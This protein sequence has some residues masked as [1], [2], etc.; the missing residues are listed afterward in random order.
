MASHRRSKRRS[1]GFSSSMRWISRNGSTNSYRYGPMCV[2][3]TGRHGR[4]K[5]TVCWTPS[6]I[7]PAYPPTMSLLG[8]TRMPWNRNTPSSAENTPK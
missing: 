2:S 7:T 5:R 4:L 1:D 6:I 8:F 3:Q